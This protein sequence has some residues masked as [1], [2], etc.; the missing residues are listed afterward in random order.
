MENK[1]RGKK[2]QIAIVTG[3]SS[4]LGREFVC[5]IA[6]RYP[7]LDEIWVVAR[8]MDRLEKLAEE[9]S[10]IHPLCVDLLTEK[11]RKVLKS[12]LKQERPDV[13]LLVLGAGCGYYGYLENQQEYKVE[14]MI[15]LNDISLTQVLLMT[16]PH[17][18]MK[19]RIIALASS[20]AFIPQPGFAVYAATKAYVRHL[21][22]ALGEEIK[23]RK[24]SVTAVCP[25]PVNTEFFERAGQEIAP[26]K[27]AFLKEAS[28]VV[29]KALDD[30]SRGKKESVYG[31]FM[32]GVRLGVKILPWSPVLF[33]MGKFT[34]GERKR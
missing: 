5:Q 10:N 6:L 27:K 23:K 33:I 4:G 8:R 31:F 7:G 29:R 26:Y 21:C 32:N 28:V 19:S 17:I 14:E 18:P 34:D 1:R 16:L 9:Y 20:A 22:L 2:K 25:G 11:G 13:R 12:N 3:A 30:A 24:I 15:A